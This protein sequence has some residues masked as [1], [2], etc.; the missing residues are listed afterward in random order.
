MIV[1]ATRLCKIAKP[2]LESRFEIT[3]F[4][5]VVHVTCFGEFGQAAVQC[6]K[7]IGPSQRL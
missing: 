7:R 4:V 2:V 5:I 3:R 1:L 6:I